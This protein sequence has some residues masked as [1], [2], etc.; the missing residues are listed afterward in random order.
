MFTGLSKIYA[1]TLDWRSETA[2]IFHMWK[3]PPN[4]ITGDET[5]V[6]SYDIETEEQYSYWKSP[7]LP[8]PKKARQMCWRVKALLLVS[9][10]SRHYALSICSWRSYS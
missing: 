8:H 6:Y 1:K 2:T 5:W 7:A 3:S 4:V 10:S 9:Q